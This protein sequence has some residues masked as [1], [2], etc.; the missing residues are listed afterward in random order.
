MA[1]EVA[2]E[3]LEK[4]S[5]GSSGQVLTPVLPTWAEGVEPPGS[6]KGQPLQGE[7]PLGLGCCGGGV[8]RGWRSCSSAG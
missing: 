4:G 1:A 3:H 8:L 5:P 6:Y 7:H 2:I